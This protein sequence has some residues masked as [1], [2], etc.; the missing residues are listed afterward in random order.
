MAGHTLI[1]FHEVLKCSNLTFTSR[2]TRVSNEEEKCNC[3]WAHV[4]LVFIN[5]DV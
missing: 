4:P 5:S 1:Q 3:Q 2:F